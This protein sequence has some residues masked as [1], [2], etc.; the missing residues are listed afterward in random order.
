MSCTVDQRSTLELQ[1]NDESCIV[2]Q[3]SMLELPSKDASCTV[4]CQSQDPEGGLNLALHDND[5]QCIESLKLEV[6][7]TLTPHGSVCPEKSIT[8]ECK[9]QKCPNFLLC[10][11]YESKEILDENNGLCIYCNVMNGKLQFELD[12]EC[13]LCLLKNKIGVCFDSNCEHY[14]CTECYKKK[15]LFQSDNE[16]DVKNGIFDI[17]AICNKNKFY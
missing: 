11:T 3:R 4:K 17:C 15:Y 5:G 12:K 9:N 7:L 10:E 1:P 8:C 14:I 6:L 16:K 13:I 2:D